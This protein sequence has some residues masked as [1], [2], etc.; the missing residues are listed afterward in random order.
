MSPGLLRKS[1]RELL[2]ATLF[3]G[4][5]LF[6]VEVVLA[7]VIPVFHDQLPAGGMQLRLVQTVLRAVLGTEAAAQ[8][9]PELLVAIPWVHPVVLA[10]AWGQ[11]IVCATR[12]PAGELDRGT[13][14]ILVSFP[15]SRWQ[16][17]SAEVLA[18]SASSG[19]V[20]LCAALGHSLGHSLAPSAADI[21]PERLVAVIANLGCLHL[22]VGGLV[23]VIASW[24]DRRG[25]AMTAAFA[26]AVVMFL[27]NYLAQLWEPARRVWPISFL[28]YYRPLET[29]RTG[30][31]AWGDMGILC[32]AA[33]ALWVAAG[34]R[35]ARRDLCTV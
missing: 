14:D 6:A 33:V 9:G 11:A 13:I 15:V 3:F 34:V 20:I 12:L 30:H 31:W 24:S 21:A 22:G 18:W 2:P 27:V 23:A 5:L 19:V 7:Y 1:L 28:K 4:A 17:F 29:L 8:V 10:I 35:F 25:K 32:A 26:L 16:I